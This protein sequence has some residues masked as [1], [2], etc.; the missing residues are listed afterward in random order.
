ML[1]LLLALTA[2]AEPLD[3]GWYLLM[4]DRNRQALTLASDLIANDPSDHDA[5]RLYIS[6]THMVGEADTV[7]HTYRAMVE[8]SP[9]EPAA[10]VA[11]AQA[12]AWSELESW[13]DEFSQVLSGLPESD[14]L[15]FRTASLRTLAASDCDFDAD[16]EL[17]RLEQLAPHHEGAWTDLVIE[18]LYGDADSQVVSDITQLA[19]RAPRH[20]Y[21]TSRLF[22]DDL[23]GRWYRKA[24]RAALEGAD[25]LADGEHAWQVWQ[26]LEVFE[27]ANDERAAQVRERL[28]SLDPGF[29]DS[30]DPDAAMHR[31]IWQADQKPD[32]SSALAALEALAQDIPASGPVRGHYQDRLADRLVGIGDHQ[33]ALDA[34]EAAWRADSSRAN[35]FAYDAA[36]AGS[37]LEAA[38]EAIDGALARLD[39]PVPLDPDARATPKDWT[40][41]GRIKCS[42]YLD[43]RGWVLHKLERQEEAAAAHRDALRLRESGVVAAH[44][45]LVYRVTGEPAAFDYLAWAKQLGIDEGSLD[46]EVSAAMEAMWPEQGLWHPD[47]IAGYIDARVA[48]GEEEDED[49]K[50]GH[51]DDNHALM[52]EPFPITEFTP[53]AGGK[54]SSLDELGEVKAIV[55]DLWAT[56]C[57]PCVAAMP[58][59]QDIAEAYADRG[60]RIVGISVD[61][62]KELVPRFFRDS[63]PPAYDLAWVGDD[64]MDSAKVASIPAL[65]VLDEQRQIQRFFIG[66]GGGDDDRLVEALDALVG[67]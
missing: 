21:R 53:V 54:V 58:H 42:N 12:L 16:A 61:D 23:S 45:G 46:E 13:C 2:H 60:V 1:S 29:A 35:S 40:E 18:R 22:G 51:G 30:P 50:P 55:V 67:D 59:L 26:A 64:G 5:H 62:R 10:Q 25:T 4:S 48:F 11:L 19:T 44:L 3:E 24:Q 27:A 34:R 47:G 31:K 28:V 33:S 43:T 20:L 37:H 32:H 39:D 17:A 14:E 8:R 15:A 9:D 6:A 65:F 56:W 38:L 49:V 57:G 36:Q 41:H 63:P 66:F 7:L 52:G